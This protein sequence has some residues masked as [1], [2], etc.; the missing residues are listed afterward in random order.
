MDRLDG[1]IWRLVIVIMI[2]IS[3]GVCERW[4]LEGLA[5]EERADAG[6]APGKP[7]FEGLAFLLLVERLELVWGDGGGRINSLD[8]EERGVRGIREQRRKGDRPLRTAEAHCGGTWPVQAVWRP[9]NAVWAS[10]VKSQST[11]GSTT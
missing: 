10:Q 5:G 6:L 8:S 1:G 4:T 9:H 7:A 2:V 3:D 11:F